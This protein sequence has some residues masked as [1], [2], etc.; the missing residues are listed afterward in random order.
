M[1][2]EGCQGNMSLKVEGIPVVMANNKLCFDCPLCNYR[3][4]VPIEDLIDYEILAEKLE[5]IAIRKAIEKR[6]IT[7]IP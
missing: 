5:D 3:M 2:C 7:G 6:R 1:K 4:K